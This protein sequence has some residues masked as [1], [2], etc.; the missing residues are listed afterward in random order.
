M[1][2]LRFAMGSI[3]FSKV[4]VNQLTALLKTIS[5]GV[6]LHFAITSGKVYKA[7]VKKW[8]RSVTFSEFAGRYPT[9]VS[10]ITLHDRVLFRF[11][12]EEYFYY[13]YKV[14][15]C[16]FCLMRSFLVK[17]QPGAR[18]FLKNNNPPQIFFTFCNEECCFQ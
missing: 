13:C 18:N 15:G 6:Y 3:V 9:T 10:K 8:Q 14:R 7:T 11:C 4:T 17:L 12:T 2:C 16:R 5:I 1:Y